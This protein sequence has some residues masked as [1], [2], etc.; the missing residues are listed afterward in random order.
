MNTTQALPLFLQSGKLKALNQMAFSR[1]K[2]PLFFVAPEPA[3]PHAAAA[4]GRLYEIS[5]GLYAVYHDYGMRQLETF[6]DYCGSRLGDIHWDK[7]KMLR[8]IE[9]VEIIRTGICHGLLPDSPDTVA[10]VRRLGRCL[11]AKQDDMV[12]PSYPAGL[13]EDDC[14]K[15]IK[16][17]TSAADD[18]YRFL[19]TLIARI[20]Q[21]TTL[22]EG[23]RRELVDKAFNSTAPGYSKKTSYFDQRVV[24]ALTKNKRSNTVI[25]EDVLQT[26]LKS[27]KD[28]LLK[29]TMANEF[30]PYDCLKSA[31]EDAYLPTTSS[32][33]ANSGSLLGPDLT[34]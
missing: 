33:R 24:A 14:E 8:H 6:L 17:L 20:S 16:E 2:A 31:I 27:I 25:I 4:S 34:I 19:E 1:L 22:T 30:E 10:F 28:G 26:W 18:G 12:W 9:N 3:R 13:S 23:F 11:N 15:I 7:Q 32:G 5:T 29:G 21:N